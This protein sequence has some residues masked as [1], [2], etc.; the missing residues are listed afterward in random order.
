M[1]TIQGEAAIRDKLAE[2]IRERREDD[3]VQL[4]HNLEG[5]VRWVSAKLAGT[6][7]NPMP[8]FGKTNIPLWA[9]V[10]ITVKERRERRQS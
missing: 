6:A 5:C 7:G 8:Y 1:P 9:I 2:L 4:A 3:L 10:E